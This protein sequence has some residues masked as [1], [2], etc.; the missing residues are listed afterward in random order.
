[1]LGSGMKARSFRATGLMRPCGMML[2]SNA[3]RLA[4]LTS[5]VVRIVDLAGGALKSPFR[6]ASVGTVVRTT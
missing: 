4:P 2:L 6:I 3:D 1:M 5:P